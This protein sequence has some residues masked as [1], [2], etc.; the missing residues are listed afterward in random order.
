MLFGL[1]HEAIIYI[2]A[3]DKIQNDDTMKKRVVKNV[4]MLSV[5]LLLAGCDLI[6]PFKNNNNDSG[7]DRV[8]CP[9]IFTVEEEAVAD[10]SNNF[11]FRFFRAADA[12]MPK[13]ANYVVS[14][15]SAQVAL[16]MALNGAADSTF[17]LM[18][19]VLGYNGMG[20]E[21]IN[22]YNKKLIDGLDFVAEDIRATFANSL[23]LNSNNFRNPFVEVLPEY[24][25]SML[26]NYDAEVEALDFSS[27][28][29]LKYVNRWCSSKTNSLIDKIADELNPNSVVMLINAIYFN[30]PWDEPFEKKYNFKD[31][32]YS[33][34][35][36]K[37][38]VEYMNDFFYSGYCKNDKFEIT[39][40]DYGKSGKYGFYVVLP[41]EGVAP[42]DCLAE[43]KA[44]IRDNE[45]YEI[46][47]VN[48]S[49]PKFKV[50]NS[51]SMI[52][53][54]ESMGMT[55]PFRNEADFSNL[56]DA[57]SIHITDATQS[58]VFMINE[59]GTEAAS[60]TKVD[61]GYDGGPTYKKVDFKV[62]RP[63]LFFVKEKATNTI[64][65]AGKVSNI[66]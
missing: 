57:D 22:S 44:D 7:K 25:I 29:A 52:P 23:W 63:F 61:I 24:K 14:P 15:Y 10:A 43:L 46:V 48:F 39:G 32:F 36:D 11:A 6:D 53:A 9:V 54:L 17:M 34:A 60:T 42:E 30:A 31:Y 19:D 1:Q 33:T 3:A 2:F 47:G 41:R 66:E 62:N 55:E 12:T 59:K 51:G 13:G 35:G 21:E 20:I 56:A 65:Y 64:L 8:I 37:Q 49:I 38:T 28:A 18:R 5:A 50:K 58:N 16:A 40:K 4:M 27:P 45:G 26:E